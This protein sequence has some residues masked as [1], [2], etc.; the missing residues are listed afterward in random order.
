MTRLLIILGLVVALVALATVEQIYIDRTY[1][2]MIRETNVLLANVSATPENE[3]KEALFSESVKNRID[4]LH[5]YW[6]KQERKM[7]IVT[8][9]MELSY[10]SDALIYA[11]N[12]IHFHNKEEASAGLERLRYLVTTYSKIYGINFTNIL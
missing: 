2:K 3:N 4:A 5:D 8:R 9:H 11:Q 1:S 12:F 10:I 6:M 7:S